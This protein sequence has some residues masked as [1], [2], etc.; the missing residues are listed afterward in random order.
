MAPYIGLMSIRPTSW[1]AAKSLLAGFDRFAYRG[2]ANAQWR[3][4]SGIE[5]AAATINA[6]VGMLRNR[7]SWVRAQFQRRAHH[8]IDDLPH[9][10]CLVEW[11]AIIQHHGGPTRLLDFTHSPYIAAFFAY[12]HASAD[13]AIW[14]VNVDGIERMLEIKLGVKRRCADTILDVN[15]FFLAH[16]EQFLAKRDPE[17]LVL[18]IEPQRLNE[19]M[20]IQQGTFLMPCDLRRPFDENLAATFDIDAE[21][22]VE[23]AGFRAQPVGDIGDRSGASVVRIILPIA[24]RSRALMDLS[25][26]NI[27][28][29]TLFPGLDGF[30][31][32]LH[33]AF[34][35][36][37]HL[38]PLPAPLANLQTVRTTPS[39]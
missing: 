23:I 32:S 39:T 5:R 2:Q 37:G 14:A 12:E 7:E 27:T 31:R 15:A 3:L 35:N 11:L 10:D 25:A 22:F 36:I 34:S 21:D 24:E 26:M 16:A 30:A 18:P 1:Y 17:S 13:A 6:P 9:P 20:S 19:R 28:A 33:S 4:L 29:A 38:V 8:Y